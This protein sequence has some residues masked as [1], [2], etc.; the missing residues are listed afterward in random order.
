MPTAKYEHVTPPPT[1]SW[2]G[3]DEEGWGGTEAKEAV[4]QKVAQ[5][6]DSGFPESLHHTT[7]GWRPLEF[8]SST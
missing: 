7:C 3:T 2:P 1:T 4:P 8:Y 6:K 5:E